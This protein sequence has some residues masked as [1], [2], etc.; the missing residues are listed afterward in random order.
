MS[1]PE[2]IRVASTAALD[3]ELSRAGIALS[4]PVLVVVG[5]AS[6]MG[7][8][9]PPALAAL[10]SDQLVPTLD[11]LGVTVVDG[12]TDAGVMR[13]IGQ[14]RSRARASFPLIGVAAA[15]TVTLPGKQPPSADSASAE[16]RHTH[17][18]IVPGTRWGD[19]SP[20]LAAAATS[21]AAGRPSTTLLVNGGAIAYTDALHSL[22]AGRSVLVLN[23]S[24]RAADHIARART[25]AQAC[26]QAARIAGSALTQ[27]V[28]LEEPARVLSAITDILSARDTAFAAVAQNVPSTVQ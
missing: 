9:P 25:G 13:L 8:E 12:G 22:A 5:G 19:E 21:I 24:G 1:G 28:A 23:G 10:C 27:I 6:G 7:S 15:G 2:V 26:D 4:R 14:A 3:A 11:R 20:W 18:I 16:T 17:L